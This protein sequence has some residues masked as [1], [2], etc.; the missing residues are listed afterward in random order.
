MPRQPLLKQLTL[1]GVE[2][3]LAE[4]IRVLAKQERIS[5]NKAALRLLRKGA[6]LDLAA[7]ASRRETIGS[8]L[9]RFIG[10]W[11]S[12]E[13]DAVLGATADFQRIDEAFWR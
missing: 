10:S 2:T 1:R 5:I 7:A 12:D 11:T 13:A 8:T 4:R 3:D 6:G 9:D